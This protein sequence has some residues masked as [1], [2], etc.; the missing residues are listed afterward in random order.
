MLTSDMDM[1]VGRA[2]TLAA[3]LA[4]AGALAP[5]LAHADELALE[6]GVDST[7]VADP[8]YDAV[9]SED[10]Y[11]SFALGVGYERSALVPGLRLMALYQTN[12]HEGGGRRFDGA[13]T[14]E[15]S[16][17][18]FMLAADWGPT[19]WG[20]LRP[21]VRL[22][23]GY[24]LQAMRLWTT[25]PIQLDRAHDFAY[26]GAIGLGAYLPM[27]VLGERDGLERLRIGVQGQFGYLGQ[28][29]ATFDGVT[30]DEDAYPEDDPWRRQPVDLGELDSSGRF[31]NLGVGLTVRL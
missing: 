2:G 23:A 25:G 12:M 24:S 30:A 10:N 31:W 28:T 6:V 22:G 26:L 15:W 11:G 21:S 19:L 8:S 1:T 18:R 3:V 7:R 20:F 29:V 5:S 9:D 16:Q 14:F 4:C 27:S 17:N 13:A